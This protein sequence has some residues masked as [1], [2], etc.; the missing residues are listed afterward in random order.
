LAIL[1]ATGSIGRSAVDVVG[2][3]A[4]EGSPSEPRAQRR[5]EGG[6][7]V[8]LLTAHSRR[9]ELEEIASEFPGAA[10]ATDNIVQ[11][12]KDA[13]P[14]IVLNGIAGAAGLEPSIAAL[15]VGADLALAN[16]ETIVM[17]GP[18][19]LRLA[20]EKGLQ[21]LPVDSEH[22]A[23]WT[24][25]N[26][27]GRRKE[28][29]GS[30]FS[31][32]ILTAS[33][34]PFRTYSKEELNNVTVEDALKHPTWKMGAKITVDSATMANKGLEVIEAARLFGAEPSQIRV[35]IHPQSIVHSMIRVPDGSLRADMSKPD[36]KLPIYRAL[37]AHKEMQGQNEKL[38]LC[39]SAAPREIYLDFKSP[40]NLTFEPPDFEKFPMLALAYKALEKGGLYP[41]V[42]NAANEAA[43]GLFLEKKIS[44]LEISKK[45]EYIIDMDW[46]C[47]QDLSDLSALPV[48]LAADKK[49]RSLV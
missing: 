23:V 11:A 10:L 43:V 34:G 1:G 24:L 18:M 15:Q 48:I 31:E 19:V 3:I 12:I 49:A 8:V 27:V 5:G 47:S 40:L 16:K 17:A 29:V 6:F 41:V 26:E 25:L 2:K 42:Y 33:G 39:A 9:Q 46:T 20:A 13:H 30:G 14:D 4:H 44:F 37:I 22:S 21:V 32:I 28:E 38:E 45:V 7:E 35:V 36:M